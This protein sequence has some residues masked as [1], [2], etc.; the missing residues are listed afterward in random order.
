MFKRSRRR[1]V[2][3]IMSV[4]AL[5]FL[6]TLAVI[7]GSSYFELWAANQNALKRY[8][9]LY[10]LEQHLKGDFH[11]GSNAIYNGAPSI[12]DGPMDDN[13]RYHVDDA[14]AFQLSTFY[15]VAVSGEGEVL[16]TDIADKTF[17]E[18]AT[19]EQYALEI[20][21]SKKEKGIKDNL[22]Y[23]ASD[24]GGYTLVAFMD[25][26]IMQGSMTTLFRYTLIFGSAAIAALFFV[27]VYL[28]RRIVKPLEES[29]QKQK[30]FISDAGHE[31]KTPVSVV[32]ANAELLS[33]EIGG[34]QWLA[35]IQY[36]NERM[37]KLVIQLLELAR[38][39]NIDRQTERLDFSR[40]VDGEALPF[41]SVA[42]EK[43]SVLNCDITHDLFVE[44]NP[45][46]LKQLVSILLDNAICHSTDGKEIFLTLK[47]S[48]R[49]VI[50]S[51]VNAGN[52]I[53]EEQTERMFERFYRVDTVRNGDDRHYG[54]GL[55]IAKAIVTAH[56]GK[57]EVRCH[58]GLVEFKVTMPIKTG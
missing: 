38:T 31:L 45:N 25:N 53:P 42:F 11:P 15:S 52:P 9:A 30:Q 47:A 32:S 27:A 57:I 12:K 16:A 22:I 51:V 19:L 46:Q 44:G 2:A 55:A 28:A 17:Y 54:L 8:A 29:Y 33:R 37:G 5:L 13:R 36:E 7:Y 40:L 3:A 43:G 35:N 20:W 21:K 49:Y 23:L 10:S 26:T 56:K 41:E 34:N 48:H 1:I 18:K 50:L 39:E 58:N 14:H 24:K 4:L 6:G